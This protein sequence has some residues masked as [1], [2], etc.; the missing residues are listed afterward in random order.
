MPHGIIETSHDV[1]FS[2]FLSFLS[3]K[4]QIVHAHV[5]RLAFPHMLLP[6]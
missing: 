1:D 4:A 6:L 3:S 5:L 2:F